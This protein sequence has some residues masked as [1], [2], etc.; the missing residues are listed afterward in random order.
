MPIVRIQKRSGEIV[1]FNPER[2]A[3][4]I[5]KAAEATQQIS[6]NPLQID[7]TF[8]PSITND[9][10]TELEKKYVFPS[11]IANVENIQDAVEHKLVENGHFEIA[12][13]FIL[14]RAKHSQLRAEKRI[15]E[16]KKID[17]QLL[18][19][20]KRDKSTQIFKVSKLR[21]NFAIAAKGFESECSFD[22][23][24]A[25]LKLT[26]NENIST[27]QINKNARKVALDL[28]TVKNTCWQSIAGRFYL[29]DLYK[30][31]CINRKLDQSEIYSPT[32]FKALFDQYIK[33]GLYNKN[34][35]NYYSPE[36][37]L[38][39]GAAL[40]KERDFSYIY[41]TILAYDRRY[42]LN[43]NKYVRELPQ[44]MYMSIAL[45]LAI[46]EPQETRL[47]F[48]IKVYEVTSSQK[49]S[50]PT[51]TLLNA[52]T[53]FHQLSS[54]FKLNVADDLRTIYHALE[55]MAQISK[56]G[57]GVGVYLGHIRSRGSYIRGM[58]G[59]SGG[60][61]P[62][63]RLINNTASAVN[64][65]GSRLGAISPTLDIWHRDVLDFLNLQTE[66]GDIRSKS[67]DIFPALSVPDLFMKRVES[68][69]NWTL[70]DPH[71]ILQK[72][73][74]RLEDLFC[75]QFESLYA[76]CEA[77]P[78]LEFKTSIPAKDLMKTFL[79]TAVETG[80]PYIFYRDTVNKANPNRHAGNIY[81]TQLCTEICQNTSDSSFISE[82]SD[83]G[84]ISLHYTPSDTV[85]CNLASI[86]IA[87][88]NTEPDIAEVIPVALRVLDNVITLN[89][90]P[91]KESQIT[92]EK[93]RS[94]GL[95]FLGLAEYLACHQLGYDTKEARIHTDKLF[96]QYAYTTLK[97]SNDLA[98]ERGPYKL[99]PGSDWSK[100]ILFNR[101]PDWY[102][103]NSSMSGK[104]LKLSQDI[105]DHGVRFSYHLAPAPNTST[106][107]V[108]GTTAGL[109]P[110]YKKFFV[111][112]NALAP[113]VTVAPNLSQSN[114]W[115]YKEY[116]HMD[117]SDIIDMIA[118]IYKWVDQSISF[119]WLINPAN[120]SPA[121]LYGYYFKAWK[122]GIKTIYYLR[123]MSGEAQQ[124]SCVSCSG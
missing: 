47:S 84:N 82:T 119:E 7:L 73:G 42:L 28:V 51:P 99:F 120:T 85:V 21:E 50:L 20:T 104:W 37:I 79:K 106:A 44:E 62:W 38:K 60:V 59:A 108:V 3:N 6:P 77:D 103:A 55:N 8:I 13:N 111:E 69:A 102:R 70:F 87:K 101:T 32:T 74:R 1:D 78:N 27:T 117:M 116:I 46:P 10:V 23:L 5:R 115:Y 56:F 14:Y 30:Q 66:T 93:Y 45:F 81:S 25:R 113:I 35:Y 118:T 123:S 24:Y 90:Y 58:K 40:N 61:I 76:E 105:K 17:N 68:G 31:A 97:A 9:I 22:E 34:F 71:E 15:E 48:A 19:V 53:N 41:S 94:I 88:V 29:M 95:G 57:G 112:T 107:S 86:N 52:R 67:F 11:Q 114:F 91:I 83:D 43:P 122:S 110:I 39:A 36:D 65:L 89:F 121:E 100:G 80:M 98:K 63:V 4:A 12:R 75:D 54:C 33:E 109:L 96:E 18:K 124:E 16:L 2:I 64:Q 72:K 49:L 26:I 92:A